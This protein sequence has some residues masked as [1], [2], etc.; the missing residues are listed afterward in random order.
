MYRHAKAAGL[1]IRDDYSDGD[2]DK[3]SDFYILRKT[4]CPAVLVENLFMTNKKDYEFLLS[5][6]G[7]D[8]LSNIIVNTIKEIFNNGL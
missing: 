6:C 7:Q 1:K 5:E 4:I 2:P 8:Q 3:E